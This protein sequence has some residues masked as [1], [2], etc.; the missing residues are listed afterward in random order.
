MEE[1]IL[2][3]SLSAISG[4]CSRC[5]EP[6]LDGDH[7][8]DRA[9]VLALKMALSTF[10]LGF[11]PHEQSIVEQLAWR[12][13]KGRRAYGPWHPAKVIDYNNEV[14]EEILDVMVYCVLGLEARRHGA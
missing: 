13:R 1:D 10:R 6:T 4:R 8:S 12:V 3:S 2:T 5:D 7:G 9:C 11:N 14:F